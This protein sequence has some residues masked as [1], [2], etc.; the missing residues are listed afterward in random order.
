MPVFGV[1]GK[2]AGGGTTASSPTRGARPP[3]ARILAA[4][5]DRELYAVLQSAEAHGWSAVRELLSKYSGNDL[6]TLI[7]EL[8]NKQSLAE[9]LPEAIG[10]GSE[11]ALARAVLGVEAIGRAWRI[12]TAQRARRV[13]QEQFREF[14]RILRGAEEHLYAAADVLA[15]TFAAARMRPQARAAFEASTGVIVSWGDFADPVAVYTHQRTLAYKN[16]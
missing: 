6:S 5:G 7:A 14:H 12:R 8:C 2:K 16:S 9:W 1:G 10:K 3:Q 15:W 13:S 11:D 4:D